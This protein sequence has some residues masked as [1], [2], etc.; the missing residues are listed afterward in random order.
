MQRG[1]FLPFLACNSATGKPSFYGSASQQTGNVQMCRLGGEVYLSLSL[2]DF[3]LSCHI[4]GLSLAT[5]LAC[6][7]EPHEK[8]VSLSDSESFCFLVVVLANVK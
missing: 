7:T 6:E 8:T 4:F 2:A 1:F 3:L 5:T